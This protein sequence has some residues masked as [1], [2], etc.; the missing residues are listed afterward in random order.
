MAN[1]SIPL[2]YKVEVP[3][4]ARIEG[5]AQQARANDQQSQLT[6]FK[7]Q[8]QPEIMAY[9][10]KE[11][12]L[13]G[14]K[15]EAEGYALDANKKAGYPDVR[16]KLFEIY[17]G[18]DPQT[19]ETAVVKQR[20]M[21][22]AFNY[23]MSFPPGDARNKAFNSRLADL[24]KKGV[25]DDA[26]AR[27]AHRTGPSDLFMTTMAD[28]LQ[29][30]EE[31]TSGPTKKTTPLQQ[32]QIEVNKSIVGKNER[33]Q[34]STGASQDPLTRANK[35]G[36]LI[37][38]LRKTLGLENELFSA[39]DPAGYAKAVQQFETATQEIYQKFGLDA[40]GAPTGAPGAATVGTG[41]PGSTEVEGADAAA[42]GEFDG[43]EDNPY[44]P[45]SEEEMID[46][47]RNGA[48]KDGD[49][50][51]NPSDNSV[52]EFDSSDLG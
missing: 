38:N 47:I 31:I 13:G 45:Q 11:R 18:M 22:E 37:Q 30:L 49:F 27:E 50:F 12:E 19:Y 51:I 7:I 9:N 20:D 29:M 15:M 40:N 21:R 17:Q 36:N 10:Q 42:A 26:T 8:E 1:S 34:P 46:M 41:V 43:S 3:D 32:S 14:Q 2:Q 6:D 48:I 52:I 4:V 28:Q 35:V 39:R 33:W 23:V 44:E 16:K 24:H 5:A 25:V